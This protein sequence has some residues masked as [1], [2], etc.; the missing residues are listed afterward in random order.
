MPSDTAVQDVMLSVN[1]ATRMCVNDTENQGDHARG[2]IVQTQKGMIMVVEDN[3]GDGQVSKAEFLA[4]AAAWLKII[5]RDDSVAVT[6]ADF[7]PRC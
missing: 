1:F 6:S 2:K 5:D 3:D 7:D 4:K